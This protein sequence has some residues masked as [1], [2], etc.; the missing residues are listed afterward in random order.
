[1]WGL[2]AG[3]GTGREGMSYNV[4]PASSESSGLLFLTSVSSTKTESLL[5]RT[6]IGALSRHGPQCQERLFAIRK[7][8]SF[9]AI[10]LVAR[11]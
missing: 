4:L 7:K 6:T 9:V 11:P 3:K 2:S 8:E 1:V 10:R 5:M